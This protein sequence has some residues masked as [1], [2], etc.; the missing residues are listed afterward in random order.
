MGGF[1]EEGTWI[2]GF[3]IADMVTDENKGV[4]E[5]EKKKRSKVMNISQEKILIPYKL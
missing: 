4:D 1:S 3:G 5:E 2:V